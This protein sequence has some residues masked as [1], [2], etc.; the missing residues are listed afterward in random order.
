MLGKKSTTIVAVLAALLLAVGIVFSAIPVFAQNGSVEGSAQSQISYKTAYPKISADS[1]SSVVVQSEH[2]LYRPG[3]TVRIAGSVSGEM[4]EETE[5]DTVTVRIMDSQGAVAASQEAQLNSE[6]EYSATITLPASA[7]EGTYR[8]MTKLEVNASILGLL[9]AEIVA[10]LESTTPAS[11]VVA[12]E[13]SFEVQAQTGSDG[14]DQQTFDINIASNS[15]VSDVELRQEQKMVVFTVDGE[16]GTRGVT[17][18]TVPKAML[19]GEMTVT[20][21]G[22]AVSSSSNDV[23]VTADTQT[24]TTFEINYG[25]SE[26]EVAVTGTNVVPE[27]PV[28]A[29]IAA[30]A[31]GSVVAVMAAGKR[32][33]FFSRV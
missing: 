23:I 18:V 2:H 33:G 29:M 12:S 26:H 11:F 15:T 7:D 14:S 4:Q 25:H 8:A 22:Q 5:S 9:D 24:E 20:I 3:E 21:D 27:F 1:S 28:T 30:V 13:S 19:S 16:T 17:Q 31:I 10:K 6:G 32:I